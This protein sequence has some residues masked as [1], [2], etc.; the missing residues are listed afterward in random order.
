MEHEIEHAHTGSALTVGVDIGRVL[1]AG[2]GPDSTFL[3]VPLEMAMAARSVDGAF[4]AVTVLVQRHDG[5]VHLVSK[6]GPGVEKKTRAWLEHHGF[7]ARTGLAPTQV[8]FCRERPEKARIAARLGLTAFV[9]DRLDVL[10]AMRAI[11]PRLVHFGVSETEPGLLPAPDW[12]RALRY[13]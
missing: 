3:G 11:V 5:R 10:S 12:A 9:D 13:L 7:Y 6:C 2:D 4:E 8:W 1:I